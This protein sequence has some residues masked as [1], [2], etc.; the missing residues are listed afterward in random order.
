MPCDF[1]HDPKPALLFP[2]KDLTVEEL[3]GT[4]QAN[5]STY[6][7][8]GGWSAC[9]G[10]GA[11]IEADDY[12]ALLNRAMERC[13][14]IS[15]EDRNNPDLRKL[16]SGTYAQFRSAR[17]GPPQPMGGEPSVNPATGRP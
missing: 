11:L 3:P 8:V 6:L 12:D 15:A 10:C 5:G 7:S 4:V 17:T 2:A 1:C 9:L 14:A 16:I 13:P